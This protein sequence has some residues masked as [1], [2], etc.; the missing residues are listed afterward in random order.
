MSGAALHGM[1]LAALA[2][3]LSLQTTASFGSQSSPGQ[4]YRE[5]AC[6]GCSLQPLLSREATKPRSVPG[7]SVSTDI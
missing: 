5:S 6:A 2:E 1:Q 7:K 3:E 4:V